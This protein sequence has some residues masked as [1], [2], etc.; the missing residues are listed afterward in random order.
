M[1]LIGG[2]CILDCKGIVCLYCIVVQVSCTVDFCGA[3]GV[4]SR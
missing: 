1:I 4:V 2:I 3:E